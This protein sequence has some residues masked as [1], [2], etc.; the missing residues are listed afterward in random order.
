MRYIHVR[1]IPIHRIDFA[2]TAEKS[3]HDEIVK[4]V[5]EMLDLQK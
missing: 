1:T 5:E 3:I 2:D 4:L